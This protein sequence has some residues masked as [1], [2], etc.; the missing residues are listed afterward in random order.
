MR[1][2]AIASG[3]GGVGK[4]N[5]TVNLGLALAR[6]GK[7][8]I[9][10]DADI[11]MANLG[12]TMGI[13]RSPISIHH[14]LM[15]EVDIKDAVYD[16][17]EGVKYVPAGLS[18]S[19][20]NRIDYQR[21]KDAIDDLAAMSDFVL[22]DNPSGLAQDSENALKSCKEVLIVTTP[23]PAALADAIKIKNQSD[24]NNINTVGVIYNMATGDRDEIKLQD[25]ETIL[26]TKA[27]AN[28]PLDLNVRKASSAQQPVIIKF[29]KAPFSK[30]MNDIALQL[31]GEEATPRKTTGKNAFTELIEKIKKLLR[32]A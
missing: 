32:L 24:K 7:K 15:G 29:P 10:V 27:L 30:A 3:K 13:D 12:L 28:I 31:I 2:I 18:M 23:E 16:G 6:L 4:T 25:V 17:P 19:R 14:V 20:L 9:I 8:V 21:L 22:V 5:I 1:S 11:V 26:E